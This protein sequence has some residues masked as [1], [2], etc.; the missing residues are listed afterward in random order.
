MKETPILILDDISSELGGG[1]IKA[2]YEAIPK[3]CQLF[4]STISVNLLP[5]SAENLQMIAVDELIGMG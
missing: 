5:F 3:D 4:I 1:Y 2:I